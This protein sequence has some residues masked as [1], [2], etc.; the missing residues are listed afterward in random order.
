MF[1]IPNINIKLIAI[2]LVYYFE[3]Y[4]ICYFFILYFDSIFLHRKKVIFNL[5]GSLYNRKHKKEA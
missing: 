5:S 1:E 4:Y 2:S 3:R